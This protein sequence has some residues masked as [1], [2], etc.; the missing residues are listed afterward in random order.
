MI[1][2]WR[3]SRWLTLV[4]LL[5]AGIAAAVF[6][7]GCQGAAPA[8]TDPNDPPGSKPPPT[9][10]TEPPV[11]LSPITGLPV[12]KTGSPVAVSTDN[13][14]NARPQSGLARADIVYEV[15]AEGGITRY[16]A[17]YYSQAPGTVGPVRS[18]RPY[19]AMLAK[20]WGAVFAHCG[21][22][23][24][25]IQPI[26]D[27]EVVD[28][29]EFRYSSL[30]W[31]DDSREAPHNLYT[32]VDNLRKVP[33]KPLPEPEKRYEFQEWTD[34]PSAGLEIQY[35]RSYTVQY[36]YM[37]K[38]Y[39]RVIRDSGL[40]PFVYQDRGTNEKPAVSNVIVQFA[41]SR[42]AY[43]D[44]GLVIDLIGEGKALYLLGGRYSEGTWKKEGVDEPT[45]FYTAGGQKIIL[46]TGQTW[47]QIVPTDAEVSELTP[48]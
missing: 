16:L 14:P 13:Y 7:G 31:R 44:G 38:K 26:R 34:K 3:K 12:V 33:A 24:K 32:S 6:L 25:D 21:G 4:C 27:W 42:V 37:D 5:L 18:A 41:K 19:F 30:Y 45:W 46:T 23:P 15:L 35:G 29:D 11:P 48:K 8:A 1:S 28:G 9:G 36:K 43:S 20:E 10:S 2:L 17:V 22:D 47:V 39:E 40:E